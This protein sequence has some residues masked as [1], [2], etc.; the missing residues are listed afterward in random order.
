[1]CFSALRLVEYQSGQDPLSLCTHTHSHDK[2]ERLSH[3]DKALLNRYIRA[4]NTYESPA[5][6]YC[7]E[8][9]VRCHLRERLLIDGIEDKSQ[10]RYA[11]IVQ[12]TSFYDSMAIYNELIRITWSRAES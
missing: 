2:E 3:R 5:H 6:G 8:L 12:S 1:M 7:V 11:A 10:R 4:N 9:S